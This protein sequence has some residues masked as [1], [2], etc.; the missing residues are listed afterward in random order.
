MGKDMKNRYRI[1]LNQA[2]GG[3][4]YVQDRITRKQESLGTK[5][6]ATAE[7]LANALNEADRQPA[8]NR[9]IAQAYLRA[10][11]PKMVIPRIALD[12]CRVPERYRTRVPFRT[13]PHSSKHRAGAS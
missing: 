1:F 5:D 6:K 9:Q 7:R 8:I 10:A 3:Y 11:D 13:R 4:F 2:R 12:Q